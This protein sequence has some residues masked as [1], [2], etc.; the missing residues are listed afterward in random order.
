MSI[1]QDIKEELYEEFTELVAKMNGL[2]IKYNLEEYGFVVAAIGTVTFSEEDEEPEMD[3]AFSV[4]ID[5]EEEL[6]EVLGFIVEGYQHQQRNDTSSI[7]Y[8][9]RKGSGGIN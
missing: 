6:D 4:N 7:D 8:W 5:N 1:P 9:L 3:I 2:I